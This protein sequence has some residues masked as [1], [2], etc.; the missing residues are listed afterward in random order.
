MEADFEAIGGDGMLETGLLRDWSRE[1]GYTSWL[2]LRTHLRRTAERQAWAAFRERYGRDA[3]IVERLNS[4]T[5]KI[6]PLGE[7]ETHQ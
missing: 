4:V 1:D 5:W 2:Y 3:Q 6:G 7:G